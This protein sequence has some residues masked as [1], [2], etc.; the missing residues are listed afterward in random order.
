MLAAL[1]LAV[2]GL[3]PGTI[4]SLPGAIR[5]AAAGSTSGAAEVRAQQGGSADDDCEEWDEE[6]EDDWSDE[7]TDE[8]WA[9]Y[10]EDEGEWDESCEAVDAGD[11]AGEDTG[12][13]GSGEYTV[14]ARFRVSGGVL[15]TAGADPTHAAQARR[16]WSRFVKLVPA[17]GPAMVSTF[18]LL[19]Q[20]SQTAWVRRDGRGGWVLGIG[21]GLRDGWDLD[22][23]IVHEYGHLLTLNSGQLR[24]GIN[25]ACSTY[26]FLPRAVH[27]R[28]AS[29]PGSPR[30][31]GRRPCAASTSRACPISPSATPAGS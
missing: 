5:S 29:R 7:W 18:E 30:S 3:L 22:Y 31:S 20:R 6:W 19:G 25:Q 24:P 9:A 1:A 13:D 11:D 27:A 12:D 17:D 4:P 14:R 23:T 28:A 26:L 2:V 16:L 8:D 10:E 15:D 21:N